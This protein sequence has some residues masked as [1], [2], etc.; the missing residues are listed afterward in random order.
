[1]IVYYMI[2][3]FSFVFNL[4]I[5]RNGYTCNTSKTFSAASVYFTRYS[6]D[7]SSFFQDRQI[8]SYVNGVALCR[9]LTPRQGMGFALQVD[10][11][12]IGGVLFA[13]RHGEKIRTPF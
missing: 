12:V 5:L 4:Y 1:M 2:K 13:R 7:D 6:Y 11:S 8:E 3:L 10:V 9:Y